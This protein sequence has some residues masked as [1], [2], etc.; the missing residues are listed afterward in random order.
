MSSSEPDVEASSAAGASLRDR[1]ESYR[2]WLASGFGVALFGAALWILH[3][4]L[5]AYSYKE[6]MGALR[7]LPRPRLGLGLACTAASYL[8]LTGYDALA[9]RYLALALRYRQIALA[10]F[11]GYAFSHNVGASFLGG[12]AIRYRLYSSWGLQAG[13]IATIVAFNGITFWLGFLLLTGVAL[14]SEPGAALSARIFAPGAEPAIGAACIAI[15]AAYVGW[16][17]VRR[18]P[19]RIRSFELRIPQLDLTLVQLGLSTLDWALAATVL[20]VLLPPAPTLGFAAFL[21]TFLLAQVAGL[22]SH[23]PGGLGVFETVILVG[24]APQLPGST[25]LGSLVAYRVIYYLVPLL[26]AGTLLGA[27]ELWQRTVV[28]RVGSLFG[29]IVPEIIPQALAVTTFLGGVILLASGATPAVHGRLGWLQSFL[30]LPVLETSHFFGSLTGVGLLLLARGLQHRLDAA[31]LGTVALLAAG[32]VFSLLKG[33]DYEEAL[34]LTVMLAALLPCHRHFYRR[35]SLLDESFTTGWS[36][37]IALVV[38]GSI[39]LL[40]LSHRHVDYSNQLWWQFDFTSNTPRALR[41]TAAA[42]V[43][44]IAIG[45]ARLLRPA[46][47]RPPVPTPADLDRAA[48]VIAATP[49]TYAHLALLGDKTLLFRDD[50]HGIPRGFIMYGVEGRSWIALGDPVAPPD[51][52]R[53]LAWRFHELSDAHAG[54]TVF[55]EV[56]SENLPLYLDLGLSL[57]K[58]GEEARVPLSAFSLDGSARKNLRQTHR[59]AERDGATFAVLPKEQV[60]A[61]LPDLQRVSDAWLGEKSTR[62]KGF[63]LGFF[64]PTYLARGP[65]AVVLREERII[66]FANVLLGGAQEEL[67]VDLMRYEPAAAPPGVMDYLF[68]ELMLW[69]RDAG[70]RWFSLGMAPFSG[71]DVRALAP[72]WSR[73]GAFLFRQGEHFYNFQGVRQYKLKYDPVWEPRYLASPGGLALPRILANVAALVSGGLAGVVRK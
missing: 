51:D 49:R 71:F 24:L 17:A 53:E 68:L 22:A 40:L 3:H 43:V 45:L 52:A 7:G 30:P 35:A 41:A 12:G 60:P 58:L 37:A 67:S 28:R 32:I 11:I 10:S 34:I 1:L 25:V 23:L 65:V 18:A 27:H 57:L 9:C 19:L 42:S 48:T 14:L 20:Y 63:S 2:P 13:E 39:W 69:G 55:Y 46:P 29:R 66:A 64:S 54:W 50:A 5:R 72:L 44:L 4:E 16:S 6:V 31:Y 73:A 59:R 15:V 8:L 47:P 70:Y 33:F 36:V 61:I 21:A 56:G 38:I 26:A 62:E